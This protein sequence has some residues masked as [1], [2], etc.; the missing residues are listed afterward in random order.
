MMQI[1][2]V[3]T[4]RTPI[5]TARREI[6][7]P[8]LLVMYQST[9]SLYVLVILPTSTG[10][11]TAKYSLSPAEYARASP[12]SGGQHHRAGDA[13]CLGPAAE[14]C[15]VCASARTPRDARRAVRILLL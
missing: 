10:Y 9:V 8:L 12:A 13:R 11:N 15:G 3:G 7:S 14:W 2:P 4:G 6:S 1:L 5:L